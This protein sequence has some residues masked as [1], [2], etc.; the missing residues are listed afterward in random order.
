VMTN[1]QLEELLVEQP[2]EIQDEIVR[3]NT[4][5]R[6]LAL[7]VA[8]LIPLLAALIGLFNAF[9]MVRLPD[10]EPSGCGEAMALA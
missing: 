4:D 10:P 9:R 3:I 7:Q 1:T 8:L 6:P 5:A 2:E